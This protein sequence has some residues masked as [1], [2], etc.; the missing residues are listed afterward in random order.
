MNRLSSG[1]WSVLAVCAG[2]VT[3]LVV[4]PLV[5]TPLVVTP[6]VAQGF[7]PAVVT[8]AAAQTQQP[9]AASKSAP[10]SPAGAQATSFDRL[11][12]AAT[13]ARQAER[14]DEAIGLYA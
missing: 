1:P 10:A 13:E 12:Q 7:S 9:P 2:L 5:V 6:L 11:V 4:T 14:W 3:P 8:A